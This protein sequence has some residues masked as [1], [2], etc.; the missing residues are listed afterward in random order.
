MFY[1][2]NSATFSALLSFNSVLGERERERERCAS[3]FD[4]L[5]AGA[6]SERLKSTTS[7]SG[8]SFILEWLTLML[9][10]SWNPPLSLLE[11][12]T[13]QD[14]ALGDYKPCMGHTESVEYGKWIYIYMYVYI[15]IVKYV[16]NE[17]EGWHKQVS[18]FSR[19]SRVV[20]G[21]QHC[22]SRW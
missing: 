16:Q 20:R 11:W 13:H 5:K 15:P 12:H 6:S 14:Q 17:N 22:S 19:F 1:R 10:S 9:M 4:I 3:I 7:T 2:D 8:W 18:N 21:K